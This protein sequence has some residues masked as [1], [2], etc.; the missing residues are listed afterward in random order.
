MKEDIFSLD[1]GAVLLQWPERLSEASAQDLQDWLDLI[2]GKIKRAVDAQ[3]ADNSPDP[4]RDRS[5]NK[6]AMARPFF[7]WKMT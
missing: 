1:E 3:L 6:I 4:V 7:R 5:S 2:G